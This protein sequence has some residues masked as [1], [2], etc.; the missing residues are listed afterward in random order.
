VVTGWR[1]TVAPTNGTAVIEGT[2]SAPAMPAEGPQ[3]TGPALTLRYTPT[4]T[5][6][7]TDSVTLVAMGPGG[8]SAA[9]GGCRG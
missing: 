6:M 1:I 4:S 8:D 9:L 2:S 5:F 7:G 3:S